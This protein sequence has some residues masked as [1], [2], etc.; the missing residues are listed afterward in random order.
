MLPSHGS[1][2]V[3]ALLLFSSFF[4][5]FFFKVYLQC[6]LRRVGQQEVILRL[7]RDPNPFQI[8]VPKV[9]CVGKNAEG[10]EGGWK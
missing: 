8:K 4:F 7:R 9:V 1:V 2:Q 6:D 3:P 10:R 5:S